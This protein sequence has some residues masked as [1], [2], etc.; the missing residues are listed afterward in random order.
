MDANIF[1]LVVNK[2]KRPELP[3][4]QSFASGEE[5]AL[6]NVMRKCTACEARSHFRSCR[7]ASK[8]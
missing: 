1:N 8:L 5:R 3:S 2:G 7:V 4:G 6:I